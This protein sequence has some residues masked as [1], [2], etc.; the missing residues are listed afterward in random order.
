MSDTTSHKSGCGPTL[1]KG[2]L[3]QLPCLG[4]LGLGILVALSAG[5]CADSAKE[6]PRPTNEAGG[7]T[8]ADAG[9]EPGGNGGNGGAAGHASGARTNGGS[10]IGLDSPEGG[11]GGEPDPSCAKTV[12]RAEFVPANFL[13]VIDSSGSMNCNSPDGDAELASRCARFPIQEDPTR[14]SKWEITKNALRNAFEVLLDK[15]QISAGLMLFP[16]ETAC[17]VKVDPSVNISTLNQAHLTVMADTLDQVTPEGETP[18]AGATIL[19]YAHLADRLRS[20]TLFGNSFVVLL[21]DGEETCAPSVLERWVEQDIPNARG[22]DI[23]TFVIGAPGSEAARPLLSSVAWEGGTASSESCNHGPGGVDGDCHFDMT[24]SIDLESE[25]RAALES[26]TRIDALTCEIDRPENPTGG[27]VDRNRV[28]VSFTPT[29]G[30][31]EEIGNDTATCAE[32]N[33][34][35][36]ST[37][38]TKILICGEACRRVQ[39]TAGELEVVFGCPTVRVR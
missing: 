22:F 11:A 12:A 15:P 6:S 23:R 29:G 30:E 38:D 14:P 39:D 4:L 36:Y 10:Q 2:R 13:F 35:Q 9:A 28:N 5:S 32:A 18:V 27:G 3:P 31:P 19:S 24:A 26:I 37:D 34:W 25:L 16:R 1:E 21:T 33:G 20:R 7:D 17:G 8:N